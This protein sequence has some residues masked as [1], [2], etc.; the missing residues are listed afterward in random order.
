MKERLLDSWASHGNDLNAFCDE[1]KKLSAIT[2]VKKA[3]SQGVVLYSFNEHASSS[4]EGISV[5]VINP[6]DIWEVSSTGNVSLRQGN[7]NRET[8]EKHDATK[9]L[10]EFE[11]QTK[12][13]LKIGKATFFTSSNLC[14]TF[15]QRTGIKGD[16]AVIPTLERDLLSARYLNNNNEISFIVRDVEGVKKVFAALSGNYAYVPQSFLCDVI[17]RVQS[18]SKL[19]TVVCNDWNVSNQLA[20]IYLEFP[21]K[22]EEI[23]TVYELNDDIVPGLYLAKS[24]VGECSI[25]VRATYRINKSALVITDEIKRKHSG[26]IDI[27]ELLNDIDELTYSKYTKLPDKLCELLATDITNPAWEKLSAAKFLSINE[28]TVKKAIKN[29]FNQIGMV[30]AIGKKNEKALYEQLCEE[31]DYSLYFTAYDIIM[32]IMMLPDR[33]SG[34][35]KTC[36]ENLSKAVGK[37]PYVSLEA[38]KSKKVSIEP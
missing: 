4:S 24:D 12:L 1:L 30:A 3:D 17:N 34:L 38:P 23:A 27:D 14:T 5:F 13:M 31:L 20:E 21:D 36:K 35:T 9:L 28:K 6:A 16:A 25:T 7:L 2:S 18:E 15:G 22:A 37:A 33:V 10:S 11:H 8:F 32:S 19:G 29:V 26:K